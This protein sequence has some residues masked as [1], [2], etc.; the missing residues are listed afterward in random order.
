LYYRFLNCGFRLGVSGGSAIGVKAMPTG[1]HRVYA[2]I[3]GPLTDEKMWAAIKAGRTFATTGPIITLNAI[4]YEI[5]DTAS[6]DSAD[7]PPLD[8]R[9]MVRSIDDL[10][11]IEIIHD[12]RVVASRDLQN[13]SRDPFL[14]VALDFQLSPKRSGWIAS[15]VLYRAPDG[16]LRQAHTSPIYISVDDKPIAS[17]W[18]A[19]YMI[20]W[21]DHLAAIASGQPDRFPDAQAQNAVLATYAAARSRYEQIALEAQRHWGD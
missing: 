20:R 11:S 10:E 12:G 5:G 8:V 21:I 4:G 3:N 16:L 6:I 15:R 1:H 9:T 2:R 7:S 17:A 18:D 14:E 19:R 13:E